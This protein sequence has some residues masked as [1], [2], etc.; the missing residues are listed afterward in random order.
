MIMK[1]FTVRLLIGWTLATLHLVAPDVAHA[2]TP[3]PAAAATQVTQATRLAAERTEVTAQKHLALG[4]KW[5]A[6]KVLRQLERSLATEI[7][8]LTEHRIESTDAETRQL[9]DGLISQADAQMKRVEKTRAL[10]TISQRH[11]AGMY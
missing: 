5:R 7:A 2:T 9:L 10:I 4:F 11:F 8:E 6:D 1:R 3:A